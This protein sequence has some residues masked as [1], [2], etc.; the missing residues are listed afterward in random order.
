MK[1]FK[2]NELYIG[3]KVCFYDTTIKEGTIDCFDEKLQAVKIKVFD[4]TYWRCVTSVL[5]IT[6]ENLNNVNQEFKVL[7]IVVKD[8]NCYDFYEAT[9]IIES[10]FGKITLVL[11]NVK[12]NSFIGRWCL[13]EIQGYFYI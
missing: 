6:F 3:D 9:C 13:E 12:D 1:D 5:K 10:L 11:R 8:G 7:R 4:E 2:G